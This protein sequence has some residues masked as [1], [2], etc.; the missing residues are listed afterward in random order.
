MPWRRRE[1]ALGTLVVVDEPGRETTETPRVRTMRASQ[2]LK[3][4]GRLRR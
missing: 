3:P 1:S 2:R 4:S